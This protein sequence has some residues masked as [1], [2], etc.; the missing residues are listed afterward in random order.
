VT[1][2]PT[3]Q[4]TDGQSNPYVPPF[5]QKGNTKNTVSLMCITKNKLGDWP[6]GIKRHCRKS[7]KTI[8]NSILCRDFQSWLLTWKVNNEVR[9][10]SKDLSFL[11]DHTQKPMATMDMNIRG[12]NTNIHE[13]LLVSRLSQASI[14]NTNNIRCMLVVM[15]IALNWIKL[16]PSSLQKY[17]MYTTLYK[18]F[19]LCHH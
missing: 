4:R 1:D 12:I 15:I 18:T 7:D 17:K 3:N 6:S 19:F 14:S 8:L 10:T 9:D 11:M 13:W 2:E 5:L 16:S